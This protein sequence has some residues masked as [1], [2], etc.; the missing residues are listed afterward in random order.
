MNGSSVSGSGGFPVRFSRDEFGLSLVHAVRALV[1][2]AGWTFGSEGGFDAARQAQGKVWS[3]VSPKPLPEG[4][5]MAPISPDC[6]AEELGL[7]FADVEHLELVQTLMQCYDYGVLGIHD[8]TAETLDDCEGSAMRTSRIVYDLER[9]TF[10]SEWT[11][12]AGE[13]AQRAAADCVYV[14]ELANARL[15]LEGGED[16]FFLEDR[17]SGWLTV[18]QLALLAGMTEASIRTLAS[19]GELHFAKER[20]QSSVTIEQAKQWLQAK[21]RYVPITT[22]E[23]RGADDIT[24]RKWS[25][26]WDFENAL[27]ARIAYIGQKNGHETVE[28]QLHAT[29]LTE[30]GE[31]LP[32]SPFERPALGEQ[33]LLDADLMRRVALALELPPERLVLRAAEVV[34]ADHLRA[35]EKQ[36]KQAEGRTAL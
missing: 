25:S 22:T 28:G 33:Q 27:F 24:A 32:G 29:G 11:Q 4:D 14:C 15:I 16:P 19:R 5:S 31:P 3:L 17:W 8:A 2:Q 18:R 35:I 26:R 7:G 13:Q 6:S 1:A 10:L 12:Y 30:L 34:Y 9:S 20:G 23:G 21:G 36:I